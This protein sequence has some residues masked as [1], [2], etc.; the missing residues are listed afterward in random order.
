M[1][2]REAVGLVF[3]EER[4]SSSRP[5][6]SVYADAVR[7]VLGENKK[8]QSASSSSIAVPSSFSYTHCIDLSSINIPL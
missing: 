6:L 1:D 5:Y 7:E 8:Q 4:N 2:L 3:C